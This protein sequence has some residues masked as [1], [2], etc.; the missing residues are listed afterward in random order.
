MSVGYFY[1]GLYHHP[2]RA[3]RQNQHTHAHKAAAYAWSDQ[4]GPCNT[5]LTHRHRYAISH[6]RFLPHLS[7]DWQWTGIRGPSARVG[8]ESVP[9]AAMAE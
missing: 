7:L 9:L 1:G 5:A 4:H 3:S 2:S 6:R 8:K